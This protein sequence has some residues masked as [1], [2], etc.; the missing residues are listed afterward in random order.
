MTMTSRQ[1]MRTAINGGVPDRLPVTTHHLMS[2][3]L[4]NYMGGI[5]AGLTNKTFWC[6][7]SNMIQPTTGGRVSVD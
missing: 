7:R 5:N 3:F 2:S 1:R 6:C 4:N